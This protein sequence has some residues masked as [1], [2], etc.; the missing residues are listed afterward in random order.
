MDAEQ[1]LRS[2]GGRSPGLVKLA[3]LLCPSVRI[4]PEL[5]R[6]VRL[7]LVPELP[8]GA[9][10]E[11]WFSPLVG[12]RGLDG[13]VLDP[14]VAN[15]LR[16]RVRTLL[17]PGVQAG[18]PPLVPGA[19]AETYLPA[20]DDLQRAWRLI[21][22]MHAASPPVLQLEEQV[23]WLAVSELHPEARI[24]AQL[25]LAVEALRRGR[26]G[27]ARWAARAL[28]RMP[29]AARGTTAAWLL[30]QGAGRRLQAGEWGTRTPDIA[31]IE[32]LSTLLPI[33]YNVP[34]GIR[35]SPGALDLGDIGPYGLSIP[36]FDTDPRVVAVSAGGQS[37]EQIIQ[38]RR[39]TRVSVDAGSGPVL[40]RTPHGEIYQIDAERE[41]VVPSGTPQ[42][43][44]V[45]SW[46]SAASQVLTIGVVVTPDKVLTVL[47]LPP[48]ETASRV[49]ITG[50]GLP[51]GG[52]A[53][54]IV[55]VQAQGSLALLRVSDLPENVQLITLPSARPAP[56][57]AGQRWYGWIIVPSFAWSIVT[58]GIEYDSDGA[59]VAASD[60]P[61]KPPAVS[62]SPVVISGA[63]VVTE[64]TLSGLI[65]SVTDGGVSFRVAS[66]GIADLLGLG[67]EVDLLSGLTSAAEAIALEF[68][69]RLP[70]FRLGSGITLDTD[71][72]M[73]AGGLT[74]PQLD[75]VRG[76]AEYVIKVG[77]EARTGPHW[78]PPSAP[79]RFSAAVVG[80]L[81]DAAE[82]LS[83][84]G[85][86][87]DRTYTVEEAQFPLTRA[88]VS[89]LLDIGSARLAPSA[90]GGVQVEIRSD[91][92]A[93][94]GWRRLR[95]RLAEQLP[96]L[97]D[98]D[99]WSRAPVPA[100]DRSQLLLG[101]I[102][103]V[104]RRETGVP[105]PARTILSQA[106]RHLYPWWWQVRDNLALA[107]VP[108]VG[109]D[110]D[111][112]E[113]IEAYLGWCLTILHH[114]AISSGDYTYTMGYSIPRGAAAGLPTGRFGLDILADGSESDAGVRL[115]GRFSSLVGF[116]AW[117]F[118]E[119]AECVRLV[120][121]QPS[122]L[123]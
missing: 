103:E 74:P 80:A 25:R 53:A 79:A 48:Q 45:V 69:M 51:A 42:S 84:L 73:A 57:V 115:I 30:A 4:E 21:E 14:V 89:D 67:L 101:T 29:E 71:A 119:L 5:L 82:A 90:Y 8:A 121:S 60:V 11:L 92:F 116:A 52:L 118:L 106:D 49:T 86:A 59:L 20:Q 65:T 123:R 62:D 6:A 50:A 113:F 109:S 10:G 18:P 107:G 100:A 19:S 56:P 87:Q 61:F 108:E 122:V 64:G 31:R 94:G 104:C 38:V 95:D 34:L 41:E 77:V 97:D 15:L 54:D 96:G 27:V 33:R 16:D 3:L 120:A 28:P 98:W 112:P 63:P 78:R 1:V 44:V 72:L 40:L 68:H 37:D 12:A 39:G 81:D 93:E 7:E 32:D 117:V 22:Q 47:P 17:L 55:T 76:A 91:R 114:V 35:R 9:E 99:P 43:S 110:Q 46:Q 88:M 102:A 83:S 58:G 24:E 36:V 85:R 26:T 2:A 70:G 111:F 105:E 75:Q 66:A 13:I 23:N